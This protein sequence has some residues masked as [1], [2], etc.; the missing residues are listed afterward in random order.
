MKTREPHQDIAPDAAHPND[1]ERVPVSVVD[2]RRV[3]KP[4]GALPAEPNLKPTFVQELEERTRR[5]ES[6][7]KQ[8]LTELEEDAARSR[9]R[10]RADLE[11]QYARK[12]KDLL[13]EVLNFLDDLDHAAAVVSESPAVAEGLALVAAR[14]GSFLER[15]GCVK[16]VPEGEPFDPETMEAVAVLEGPADTVVKVF[17]AGYSREGALL[18]PAQVAV[19]TGQS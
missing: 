10:I 15:H 8:R 19:G 16:V 4:G 3:G 5:A 11:Q 18:R 2:R 7:L 17:R 6:S 9:A 1:G 14:A 12:E 13:L